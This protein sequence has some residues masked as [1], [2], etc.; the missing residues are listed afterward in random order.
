M[1]RVLW[2]EIAALRQNDL[3][4][5]PTSNDTN[6]SNFSADRLR[7]TDSSIRSLG[8]MFPISRAMAL[9]TSFLRPYKAYSLGIG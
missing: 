5:Y 8:K 2:A 1:F 7:E 6:D 3:T 4:Y 9:V